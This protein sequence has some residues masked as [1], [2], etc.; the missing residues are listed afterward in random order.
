VDRQQQLPCFRGDTHT[1]TARA[2]ALHVLSHSAP[3]DGCQG[4]L[5]NVHQ[6]NNSR[7]LL[8]SKQA[9][10]GAARVWCR[11]HLTCMCWQ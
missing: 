11:W 2:Q 4:W 8:A 5:C 1:P 7:M 10:Q 6:A 9:V 3:L